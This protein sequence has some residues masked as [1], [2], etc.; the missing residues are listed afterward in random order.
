[1]NS[2]D[3]VIYRAPLTTCYSVLAK[4]CSSEQPEF[5]VMMKK[6]SSKAEEKKC[7]IMTKQHVIEL[8]KQPEWD[9][10]KV[11]VNGEEV[12]S[13]QRLE[14]FGIYKIGKELVK[15]ELDEVKV[16]FDGYAAEISVSEY[17]KNKQCGMCGHFDGERANEFRRADNEYTDDME[18][19]HRSFL[20]QHDE[21]EMEE[22]QLKKKE[23]YHVLSK[24]S[25]SSEESMF[26]SDYYSEKNEKKSWKKAS[27]RDYIKKS[28][29]NEDELVEPEEKTRVIE[30]NG[31]VCFSQEAVPECPRKSYDNE[32]DSKQMKVKFS[33]L[34]RYSSEASRLLRESRYD[35]VAV[36]H[37]KESFTE[38]LRVPKTCVVY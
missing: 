1:V 6:I 37:I 17:F 13:E 20:V 38:T 14:S 4:D 26:D 36:E 32:E 15:V 3:D 19:F 31:K 12:T 8:E 2:F 27:K 23:N 24:E 22:E 34:P 33:C 35:I 16:S 9:E 18:Q 7:K 29:K 5:A 10:V 11:T 30:Q 28:Y 25:S 21:C